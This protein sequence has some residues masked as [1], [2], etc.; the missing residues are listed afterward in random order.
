MN[1]VST[2]IDLLTHK[3][4]LVAMLAPSFPIVYRY[5]NIITMLKK[6]G[7]SYVAEVAL[8]AE[9]TNEQLA[10]LM[11]SNPEA[12]YITSPCPTVVRMVKKTMPQYAKYFTQ[13]VDSP[14]IAT[15]KIVGKTYPGYTPV[16]IGPCMLK[17]MEAKEDAAEL[18]IVVITFAEL[19]QIF[20]HFKIRD[21]GKS[22]AVFDIAASGITRAYP[23][24]GGLS[25]SS[26]LFYQMK[27][28]AV[29]TVCGAKNNIKAIKE[30]DEDKSVKLLDIL[31]CPGGCI[32]GPGIISTQ[33]IPE[34]VQKIVDYTKGPH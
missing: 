1:D 16:F 31:N 28:G 8:G 19:N 33:T 29:K 2:L 11:K 15:A 9:K 26:K 5:P 22:N 7:F 17:K 21:E 18:K 10:A 20:D 12:R 25:Y 4:K 14:M 23:L 6:L 27:P 34:R 13:S 24:D 3:Q 32:S 30:F